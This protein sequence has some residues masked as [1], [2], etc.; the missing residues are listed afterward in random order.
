MTEN[1]QK[2]AVCVALGILTLFSAHAL[3]SE[4]SISK[5][6][7]IF[8]FGSTRADGRQKPFRSNLVEILKIAVEIADLKCACL[9]LSFSG[10]H[11]S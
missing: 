9:K 7:Q 3:Y 11:T 2:L 10:T 6:K 8:E 4:P 1:L 5:K